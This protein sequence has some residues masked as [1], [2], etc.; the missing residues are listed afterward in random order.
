MI[1]YNDSHVIIIKL[2]IELI[3]I[4]HNDHDRHNDKRNVMIILNPVE[5]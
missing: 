2:M 1:S 3:L 4:S 5:N